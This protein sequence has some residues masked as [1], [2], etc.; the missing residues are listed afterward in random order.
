MKNQIFFVANNV[1][2]M[3]STLLK[4]SFLQYFIIC[5]FYGTNLFGPQFILAN[6]PISLI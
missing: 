2:L 3:T 4:L 6:S 5:L 1:K